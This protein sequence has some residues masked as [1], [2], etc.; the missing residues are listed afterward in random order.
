[1]KTDLR[2]LPNGYKAQ[3]LENTADELIGDIWHKNCYS[4][5]YQIT[6]DDVVIDI[7]ANQGIFSLYA[8]NHGAIVY[9]IEP[10]KNNYDLLCA[11]IK[12]NNLTDRIFPVFGAVAIED[13]EITLFV[14]AQGDGVIPSTFT[15]TSCS[16]IAS[17]KAH[18][19]ADVQ[20][21]V[22]RAFTLGNF[23][24]EMKE[25]KVKILKI[26]TEGAEMDI[27]SGVTSTE[28][29][30]VE[31][32]YMET[33][34]AYEE[35]DLFLK[36]KNLGF[37]VINYE[38][39]H[40]PFKTGYLHAQRKNL[41]SDSEYEKP[42][43]ILDVPG[44]V[45]VGDEIKIDAGKS[46][47]TK[48]VG[49]HLLYQFQIDGVDDGFSPNPVKETKFMKKGD[50]RIALSVKDRDGREDV[51]ASEK[52]VWVFDDDYKVEKNAIRLDQPGKKYEFNI[53]KNE[54]F[55]V[56]STSL[57]KSW[58]YK[59]LVVCV[60]FQETIGNLKDH[61]VKFHFNGRIKKIDGNY[62][63]I[64]FM[65]FPNDIDLAFS[66]STDVEIKPVIQ[67]YLKDI[68]GPNPRLFL[69]ENEEEIY[70]MDKYGVDHI[71]PVKANARFVIR[72]SLFPTNYKFGRILT[73]FSVY[74]DHEG[75]GLAGML[76]LN[77]EKIPLQGNLAQYG[78]ALGDINGDLEFSIVATESRS[79]QITWWAE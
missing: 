73:C 16:W 65:G 79:Y 41:Q 20:S 58:I 36:I 25:E 5:G 64:Y 77:G 19:I 54:N 15:S 10:Q 9:A 74:N 29:E 53:V 71:C 72:S 44:K 61:V 12:M 27:L 66:L 59:S 63:E 35:K 52:I 30:K 43:A 42:V 76:M 60:Y 4:R 32:I 14:P 33:H 8:A 46:F 45:G 24:K 68:E 22:V 39:F 69:D 17:L 6:K 40:G 26:D 38:K 37:N 49:G 11:N 47:S 34:D 1:M 55:F 70:V 2:I 57:P 50:H 23:L 51:D 28:M 78:V 31:R 7:G 75:K 18:H 21:Y 67:W 56:S 13:G 62:N 48:N 3:L